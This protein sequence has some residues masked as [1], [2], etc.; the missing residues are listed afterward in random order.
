MCM[1]KAAVQLYS[2]TCA[3]YL[4]CWRLEQI[5]LQHNILHPQLPLQYVMLDPA[6]I[7]PPTAGPGEH[8]VLGWLCCLQT[9]GCMRIC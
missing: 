9:A 5:A 1:L 7:L 4:G 2:C 3:D 6:R 8:F